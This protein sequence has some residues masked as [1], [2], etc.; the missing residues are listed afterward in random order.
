MYQ[1][2]KQNIKIN[3]L[4]HWAD[5]VFKDLNDECIQYQRIIILTLNWMKIADLKENND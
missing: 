5:F 1:S 4:I 3:A 2:D